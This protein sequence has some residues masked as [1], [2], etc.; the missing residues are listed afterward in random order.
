MASAQARRLMPDALMGGYLERVTVALVGGVRPRGGL[1]PVSALER[2]HPG[3]S[4]HLGVYGGEIDAVGE[5]ERLPEDLGAANDE[6]FLVG[7]AGGYS[8]LQRVRDHGARHP[9]AALARHDHRGA[10]GQQPPDRLPGLASHDD[11]MP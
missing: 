1:A 10:A 7:T 2:R 5:R 6:Y 8:F 3:V 4:G 11:V 9:V